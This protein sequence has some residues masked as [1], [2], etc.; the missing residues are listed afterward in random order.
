MCNNIFKYIIPFVLLKVI[1]GDFISNNDITAINY[2]IDFNQCIQSCD[3][4]QNSNNK[5]CKLNCY[6]NFG[7][8]GYK[9]NFSFG[10]APDKLISDINQS[11][12]NF[13]LNDNISLR[14][15]RYTFIIYLIVMI[16]IIY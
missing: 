6:I 15:G 16:Y 4:N 7:S 3:L 8:I 13:K 10:V 9:N 5:D 12:K 14:K 1:Y 11:L 2:I